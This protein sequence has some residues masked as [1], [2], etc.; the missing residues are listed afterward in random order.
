VLTVDEPA[1]AIGART[2]LLAVTWVDSFTGRA[3]DLDALG[4]HCR[5]T[6]VLLVV[7]GSQAVGARSIDVRSTP[8]DALVSC[9]YKWLCGPYATGF[10]WL[11]ADL[12]RQVR[13]QQ[14]YWLAMQS[15]RGLDR[16]RDTTLRDDLGVRALD[17]FCPAAF[18][19]TLPLTAALEVVLRAD[20]DA[21]AAW[22][23]ALV[24]RLVA[25]LD[26]ESYRLVSPA[27]GPTRSTLVVIARRDGSAGER[28]E[29]LTRAG[30]DTAY[31]E[32]NLRFSMHLFNTAEQV[33]RAL[34]ALHQRRA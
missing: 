1:T 27:D 19:T 14:A 34:D 23:Q 20:V 26:P 5:R 4:D 25:G 28:H 7:N 3:L 30:I 17:V 9:G 16:M 22:D 32:G 24:E 29:L 21:I 18:S 8:V 33:D 2:R 10:A 11:H 12:L 15:G 13:P 6:G 31:R